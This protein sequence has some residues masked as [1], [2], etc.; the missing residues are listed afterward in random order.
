MHSNVKWSSAKIRSVH[1]QSSSLGKRTC[2]EM[3]S[4]RVPVDGLTSTDP[5]AVSF[6]F[7]HFQHFLVYVTDHSLGLL[8]PF[9]F[10]CGVVVGNVLPGRRLHGPCR[11]TPLSLLLRTNILQETE[12]DVTCKGKWKC[13]TGGRFQ[14][15]VF[16]RCTE[17]ALTCSTRHIQELCTRLWVHD[18]QQRVL[19]QSVNPKTHRII[20]DVILLGHILKHLVH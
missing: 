20:H 15:D 4:W 11:P 10:L 2:H 8:G 6:L 17:T 13:D 18:V 16:Q 5:H 12:G 19:P 3:H 7:P 14:S 9:L 1:K